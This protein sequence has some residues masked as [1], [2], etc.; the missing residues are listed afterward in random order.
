MLLISDND[1]YSR[2]YEFLGQEYINKKLAEKGYKNIRIIQRFDSNCNA[3]ANRYTN[4]VSFYNE[5]GKCIYNQPLQ[6]NTI[7]YENPAGTIKRG[8]AYMNSAGKLIQEPKDFTNMNCMTLQ[9]IND[10]LK[11]IIFP[12]AAN[13]HFDLTKEDYI[14]LYNYLSMYPRES[15]SPRYDYKKFEDSYKKYLMY[16]SYHKKIQDNNLRIFNVVGQ[17]YGYLSDCAYIIDF[18]KKIEFFLSASIYVNEDG[19]MN[20]GKYDYKTVG[21]PFFTD[22]GKCDRKVRRCRAFP[23]AALAINGKNL[24]IAEIERGIHVDL[25]APRPVAAARLQRRLRL[26]L[27]RAAE[28]DDVTKRPPRAGRRRGP[29]RSEARE[30]LR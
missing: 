30:A 7:K 17:S 20:D 24:G 5:A 9:D 4:P 12:D 29:R 2:I 16:G 28:R 26:R 18:D 22:L 25:D 13:R 27:R 21:F 10:I 3:L 8:I 11:V 14:F 23:D 1:A 6:S 15:D 19:V